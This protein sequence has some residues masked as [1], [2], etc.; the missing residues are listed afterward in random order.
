MSQVVCNTLDSIGK[1][2]MAELKSIRESLDKLRFS[3]MP[4]FPDIPD[5]PDMPEPKTV[6]IVMTTAQADT[7]KELTGHG[8][9]VVRNKLLIHEFKKVQEYFAVATIVN[10]AQQVAK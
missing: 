1:R 7:L 8:W 10:D 9:T 6:T 5:F 2:V 4:D 3:K